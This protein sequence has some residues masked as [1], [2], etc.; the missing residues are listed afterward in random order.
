[1]TLDS[2]H[3]PYVGVVRP[4]ACDSGRRKL[5]KDSDLANVLWARVVDAV[6]AVVLVAGHR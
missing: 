4:V 2:I 1:M 6:S 3:G 5:S